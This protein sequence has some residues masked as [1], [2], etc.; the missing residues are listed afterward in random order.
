M[1]MR[2]T[3]YAAMERIAAEQNKGLAPLSDDLVLL[4]S[5]STRFASPFL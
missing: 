1:P 5:A 3:V 2:A 4:E